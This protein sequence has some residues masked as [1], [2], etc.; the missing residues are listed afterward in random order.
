MFSKI[1]TVVELA[2][3]GPAAVLVLLDD[4]MEIFPP[5]RSVTSWLH[6]D[7]YVVY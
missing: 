2:G 5:S 6:V 7:V 3:S 4:G 1:Y